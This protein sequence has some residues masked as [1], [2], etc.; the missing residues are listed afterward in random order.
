MKSPI[1][2]I[3]PITPTNPRRNTVTFSAPAKVHVIG[4]HAVVYGKPAIISAINLRL[5]LTLKPSSDTLP[6][7]SS[8]IFERSE[9]IRARIPANAGIHAIQSAIEKEVK[10]TYKLKTLPPY[11]VEIKSEFPAGAGL[12]AS[13]AISAT[14][15]AAIL[16]MLKIDFR[17][18]T[19]QSDKKQIY[20]I[21]LAGEK[22]IHGNPSGSDLAAAIFGGTLWFRRELPNLS[23]TSPIS[24]TLPTLYLIDSGKPAESTG[25]MVAS[26]AKLNAPLKEKCFNQLELL[27]KNLATEN[28][29]IKQVFKE[30]N[31]C[32]VKLG[33]V[34][35]STQ[36]LINKIEKLGGAAKITGAGGSKTGS[37]MIIVYLP[38][39]KVKS[40]NKQRS[41]LKLIPIKLSRE[42]LRG[43]N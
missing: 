36:Q 18:E 37:G 30:T 4:E 43:E 8:V 7:R 20:G 34:S 24:L 6:A 21:A 29:D 17:K 23:L 41:D 28:H 27:T 22:A 16:K 33:V 1:S 19:Y 40:W 5:Y 38:P 25:Q 9:K 14:L 10:K 39:A 31:T 42:G 35:K 3:S 13:A 11:E 15:A 2:H 32:L 12:G 26:V